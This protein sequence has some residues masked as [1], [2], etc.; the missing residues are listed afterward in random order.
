M[1]RDP[2]MSEKLH[3]VRAY[4]D[5]L[6]DLDQSI[7]KMGALATKLLMDS[8]VALE[9]RNNALARRVIEQ[10]SQIDAIERHVDEA[11]LGLI[12]LRQPMAA[13]LRHIAAA[14]KIA[15][16]IER[17]GDLAKNIAKRSLE[18]DSDTGLQDKILSLRQMMG[19]VERQFGQVLKSYAMRD[20]DLA[21]SVWRQDA[22]IDNL[23]RLFFR[24]LL[25]FM[26]EDA[27]NIGPCAHLMFIAKN[28]ERVGDHTTNIAEK[29]V[30]M[31]RGEAPSDERPRG[32][33]G[34]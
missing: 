17:I 29:V 9:S 1:W 32:T 26:M 22:E 4:D 19:L 24:A 28:L 16:A 27:R 20:A 12:A 33:V 7:E 25:T 2:E 13:D 15:G 30:F 3:T 8:L 5:A 18:I 31:V 11:A 14:M 21:E 23:Y 10:D 6:L 34:D